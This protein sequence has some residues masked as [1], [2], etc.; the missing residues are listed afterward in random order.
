MNVNLQQSIRVIMT[1][2]PILLPFGFL[3]LA[4]IFV[5]TVILFGPDAIGLIF[6]IIPAMFFF[7]LLVVI[8]LLICG[9]QRRH[10][11]DR[12]QQRHTQAGCTEESR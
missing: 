9:L 10:Y 6:V 2:I 5:L 1:P 3:Q 12:R 4:K 11:R 8:N 7:A